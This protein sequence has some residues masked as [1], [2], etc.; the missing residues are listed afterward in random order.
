MRGTGV[1]MPLPQLWSQ[2]ANDFDWACDE[3]CAS[4]NNH[5]NGTTLALADPAPAPHA[6]SAW[7]HHPA[8][9]NCTNACLTAREILSSTLL[10]EEDLPSSLFD[11]G[12]TMYGPDLTHGALPRRGTLH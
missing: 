4:Y 1:S 3:L 11:A 2:L 7:G 12:L 5:T 9:P 6:P 8:V 10:S